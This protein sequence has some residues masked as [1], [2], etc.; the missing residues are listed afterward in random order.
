M[1]LL[2]R[3][4]Q[5]L[6]F[7]TMTHSMNTTDKVYHINSIESDQCDENLT[8][9]EIRTKLLK[10]EAHY[11]YLLKVSDCR[12]TYRFLSAWEYNEVTYDESFV[13]HSCKGIFKTTHVYP[14]C[15]QT[16][17]VERGYNCRIKPN[18]NYTMSLP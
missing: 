13:T 5:F 3:A 4:D 12:R 16:H 17:E 15:F 8:V 18:L 10:N 6:M 1:L 9:I 2:K 7:H 14:L 11:R